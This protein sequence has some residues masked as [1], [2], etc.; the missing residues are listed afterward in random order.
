[1]SKASVFLY[2]LLAII[3]CLFTPFSALGYDDG[4]GP[5]KK[6]ESKYFTI[7]YTPGIDPQELARKLDIGYSDKILS[8]TP[9]KDNDLADMLDTLYLRICDILDMPLYSYKGKIKICKGSQE[10]SNIYCNIYRADLGNRYSFYI[11][12]FNTIYIPET[13]FR[14]EV[15]GHEIAHAIIS[16]Y[17]VVQPPVKVAEVL[18]GYVEYQLRKTK[19]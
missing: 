10:L 12:D 9:L 4:F 3:S 14:R 15:M 13:Y 11:F 17:F 19:R 7:F 16:H 6:I 5:A 2:G 18:A 8:G 1:M